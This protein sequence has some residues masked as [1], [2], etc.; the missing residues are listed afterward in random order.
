MY[1][2]VWSVNWTMSDLKFVFVCPFISYI[3]ISHAYIALWS[4]LRSFGLSYSS[5]AQAEPPFTTNSLPDFMICF[6]LFCFCSFLWTP[7]GHSLIVCW[8]KW[9]T[10][11]STVLTTIFDIVGRRQSNLIDLTKTNIEFRDMIQLDPII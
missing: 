8:Y 5:F 10:C 7:A 4:S 11:L 2:R 3:I 6:S 9:K 1:Q